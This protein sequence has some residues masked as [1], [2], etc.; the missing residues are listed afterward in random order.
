M[1]N[2]ILNIFKKTE[3]DELLFNSKNQLIEL[4]S[5][6]TNWSKGK[7][8]NNLDSLIKEGYIIFEN[9]IL[10]K[11]KYIPFTP[12]PVTPDYILQTKEI[13]DKGPQ[14]NEKSW[15]ILDFL[16]TKA[17]NIHTVFETN[18]DLD[19]EESLYVST[20]TIG[21]EVGLSQGQVV[22]EMHKLS[23]YLGENFWRKPTEEEKKSRKYKNSLSYTINLPK[24]KEL[25]KIILSV[26]KKITGKDLWKRV[27]T[28]WSN[29][30]RKTKEKIQEA[31]SDF[32]K[33][34]EEMLDGIYHWFEMKTFSEEKYKRYE[35]D[36]NRA[37]VDENWPLLLE[38]QE[39]IRRGK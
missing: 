35:A 21:K 5:K 28:N 3:T 33:Y 36:I 24:R 34:Q 16:Y 2:E 15:W 8:K 4:L 18:D 13:Q 14:L 27:K 30:I 37:G 12:R 31:K 38:I 6:D 9:N 7:V 25:K 11:G 19:F 1:K 26:L 29:F 17:Y 22:R 23:Y 39:N 20:E 32:K 10:K